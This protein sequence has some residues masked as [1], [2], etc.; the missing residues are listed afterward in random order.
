VEDLLHSAEHRDELGPDKPSAGEVGSLEDA[1]MAGAAGHGS[2][3][4][5]TGGLVGYCEMLALTDQKT[6]VRL[7]RFILV[8]LEAKALAKPIDAGGH[9][10]PDLQ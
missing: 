5:G 3:G 6:F 8:D 1:I 7:L 10:P 4:L 9:R 2:D